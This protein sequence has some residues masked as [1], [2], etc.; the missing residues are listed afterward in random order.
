LALL[1]LQ[2]NLPYWFPA[3]NVKT[4]MLYLAGEQDT[5]VSVDGGRRTAAHY[6]AD[7]ILVPDAAHNLMMDV[8]YKETAMQ[9]NTRLQKRGIM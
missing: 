3:E 8:H 2:H 1:T 9:I 5:V 6:S 4:P 7:F